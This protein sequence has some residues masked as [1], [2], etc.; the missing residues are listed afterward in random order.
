MYRKAK[1]HAVTEVTLEQV[2][3]IASSSAVHTP[4]GGV[5]GVKH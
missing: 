2:V 4:G 1:N 5:G 3:S